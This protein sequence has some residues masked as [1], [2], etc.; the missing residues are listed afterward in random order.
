MSEQT[1][2]ACLSVR[3]AIGKWERNLR[4]ALSALNSSKCSSHVPTC[5]TKERS[6]FLFVHWRQGCHWASQHEFRAF[7]V[8]RAMVRSARQA[9]ILDDII[10]C[11]FT[12]W[13]YIIGMYALADRYWAGTNISAIGADTNHSELRKI[14]SRA[15]RACPHVRVS[16]QST[17]LPT[18][19]S[20]NLPHK[21]SQ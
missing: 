17:P 20:L 21:S 18:N 2:K 9:R 12:A 10:L 19:L 1:L 8:P 7:L 15:C 3:E 4:N 11:S 16:R 5:P 6:A 13:L 14:L